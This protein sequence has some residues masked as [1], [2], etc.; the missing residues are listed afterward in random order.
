MGEL[1]FFFKPGRVAVIGAS[2]HPREV[3][4]VIFRNFLEGKFKGEVFPVNPKADALLGRKCFP[5]I[6]KI[7]GRIDL[8]VISVPA[9][10]VPKVLAE[11][12]KKRVKAVIII[13]GGFKEIGNQELE[14]SV[15]EVLK[16]YKIRCVGVNCLGVFDPY[17][18]VDTVFLPSYKLERPGKG[19]I[20]FITQSGAVGSVI[21]DWMAM[22]NYNLSKFVSYGNA[23]DIDETDLIDYMVHDRRTKVICVYLEGVNE[24]RRFF[25]IAKRHAKRKPIIILKAGKT[26][27]GSHAVSSH[28]GSLA[29]S[30]QIYDAVFKQSG[31]IQARDLEQI[32]DFA[33]ILSTQPKPS[34]G[35]VQVITDG[36]GFG[37][38][39]VDAL[40]ENGLE[41]SSMKPEF[42]EGMKKQMPP[43]VVLKNP[44]DLTGDAT[45]ERYKLAIDAAMEDNSVD[46]IVVISLFQVP[47]LTPDIVEVIVEANTK[48]KKPMVVVAAGGRYTE[49]LKKTLEGNGIP[50]FSY[51]ERAAESLR[52]LYEYAT[53]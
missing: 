52:A 35:K 17:S 19:N 48:R 53:K 16:K 38:L 10:I 40:V 26:E 9:A 13:S 5:S 3:G 36:G 41:L 25:E 1:D 28:T 29:G 34:G 45:T 2:R 24:G 27:Q 22:K 32:F 12:G 14:N 15:K 47:M 42:I 44:I 31:I 21:L 46:M 6:L 23:T 7:P 8:A 43:Y 37:I 30:R 20:A 39:T 11:C 49:V 50:T 51:P 4:H 18:G 33:R